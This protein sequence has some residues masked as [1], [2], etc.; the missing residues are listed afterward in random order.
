MIDR[1][2]DPALL[3]ILAAIEH[4]RWSGWEDWRNLMEHRLHPSGEPY[5]ERWRRLRVTFYEN[6]TD[7]ERES[8]RIEV[9]MTLAAIRAYLEAHT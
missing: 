1:L 5:N 4:A 6:L 3:E 8:D 9:R 2:N 7:A